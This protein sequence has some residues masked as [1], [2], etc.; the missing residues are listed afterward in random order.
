MAISEERLL[1]FMRLDQAEFGEAIDEAEAREVAS[2]LVELYQLLAEA[3]P[4]EGVP[5]DGKEDVGRTGSADR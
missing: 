2:R 1:E 4:G 3:L 5:E